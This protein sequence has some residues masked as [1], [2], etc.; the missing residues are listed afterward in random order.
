MTESA[1]AELADNPLADGIPFGA[2][3]QQLAGQRGDDTAVTV[4]ALDGTATSLTFAE[5]DARANQWGRAWPPPAPKRVRL[6]HLPFPT[7]TI[8]CWP[9]W[10]AGRSARCPCPCIGIFP[11]GNATG[12]AR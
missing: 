7:R 12:C 3:L 11:N 2:K 10:G 9:R 6:S 1:P 8:W 5:L 4:V